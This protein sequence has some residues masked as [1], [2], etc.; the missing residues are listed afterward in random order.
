VTNHLTAGPSPIKVVAISAYGD[1]LNNASATG[2]YPCPNTGSPGQGT[3]I[4]LLTGGSYTNGVNPSTICSTIIAMVEAATNSFNNIHLAAAGGTAPFTTS[5]TPAAGY[6]PVSGKESHDYVFRV[7][8]TGPPC[9]NTDQVYTGTIDVI[10]DG[11]IVAKKTV[12]ITVHACERWSYAVKF[13]CGYVKE[14]P[15]GVVPLTAAPTLRPGIYATEVNILNY[16]DVPITVHK[17]L[18]PLMEHGEAAGREPHSV[19]RRLE[20]VITLREHTATFDDC[21]RLHELM[22]KV[23]GDEPLSIGWLELVSPVE[24]H[25]AAVYTANDLRGISTDVNVVPV[26]GK[27]IKK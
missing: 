8:F 27:M 23:P 18:Y 24:L 10:G 17:Y 6:G 11:L 4:A 25:V 7:V 9:K 15:P 14:G 3:Q 2:D 5:I 22:H 16:L 21:Q 26:Q 20:D 1:G 13:I 12:R 19:T